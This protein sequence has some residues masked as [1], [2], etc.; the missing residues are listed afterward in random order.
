MK[1]RQTD[2]QKY[3]KNEDKKNTLKKEDYKER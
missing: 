3:K 1:G 2:R